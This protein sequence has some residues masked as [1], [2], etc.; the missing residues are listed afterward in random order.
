MLEIR[1]VFL[2]RSNFFIH[3]AYEFV[4]KILNK[5]MPKYNKTPKNAQF[6]KG[7]KEILFPFYTLNSSDEVK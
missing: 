2:V 3:V 1:P 7:G 4:A 6:G 5:Y